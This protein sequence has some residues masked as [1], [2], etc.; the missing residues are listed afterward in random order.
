MRAYFTQSSGQSLSA[1]LTNYMNVRKRKEFDEGVVKVAA[2]AEPKVERIDGF[3]WTGFRGAP[4]YTC[5]VRFRGNGG[6]RV[7]VGVAA[8]VESWNNQTCKAYH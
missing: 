8:E 1:M 4:C 5:S 7:P 2:S 6:A 3:H